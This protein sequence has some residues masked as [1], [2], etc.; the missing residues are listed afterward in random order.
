[1]ETSCF[2]SVFH[3]IMSTPCFPYALNFLALFFFFITYIPHSYSQ[4]SPD[5]IQIKKELSLAESYLVSFKNDSARMILEKLLVKLEARNQLGTPLGIRTQLAEATALERDNKDTAAIQKLLHVQQ[6]SREGELWAYFSKSSLVLA[7]L[8][9]KLDRPSASLEQLRLADAAIKAYH[10]EENYPNYAI[11]MASWQRIFG[12]RDSA[13]F[14]AREALAT[15]PL[16][17]LVLEEAIGHMLMGML[18]RDSSDYAS[19]QHYFSGLRL[20]KQLEDYTGCSYMFHGIAQ[21]YDR[22]GKPRL[23]L[24]YTDSMISIAKKAISLGNEN[25]YSLSRTYRFRGKLYKEM[26]QNDSAFYYQQKGYEM[27]L[28][29]MQQSIS[30][31]VIEI[32]AK[33]RDEKKG[34]I[35]EEQSLQIK[36]DRIRRNGLI[37]FILITLLFSTVLG[38]YYLRLKKANEKTQQQATTLQQLIEARS[39]FFANISHELRTPL[40]LILGPLSAILEQHREWDK[41]II[42]SQLQMIRRNGNSLMKLVE[43]I[44]DITRLEQ[45]KMHL[46]E[47][48][49]NLPAFVESIFSNFI[50]AFTSQKLT[51]GL[52][53]DVEKSL[54][55]SLDQMKLEKVLNNFLSNAMKHTSAGGDVSFYLQEIDDKLEIKISDTGKGIHPDDLPFIFDRFYQGKLDTDKPSG[56][57]GIGLSLVADIANLMGAEVSVEST[58]GTGSTFTFLMPKNVLE[59]VIFSGEIYDEQLASET[60]VAD[61]GSDFSI[62]VVEDNLDMQEFIRQSLLSRF[63]QV[64][65]AGNGVEALELLAKKGHNIDLIVTDMMMPEMDGLTLVETIREQPLLSAI[66]VIM[67]TALATEEDRLT[68]LRTGVDDYLTK[69]FSVNE[70]E[71]RAKNLLFNYQQRRI[72]LQEEGKSVESLDAATSDQEWMNDLEQTIKNLLPRNTILSVEQLAE[73]VHLSTRQLS[74]KVKICTGM[75]PGKFI[76]EVQLQTARR[77]ITESNFESLLEVA[78]KSGFEHQ[79]TFSTSFKNRFGK[80]PGEYLKAHLREV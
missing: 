70:L 35:L 16:Y 42:R 60:L 33:Y 31:K 41:K 69:P 46:N 74:R 54:W 64:I 43:E 21:Y 78:Q 79:T 1:M 73:S 25:H 17:G 72:W 49:I 19:V 15:A 3:C 8:Y 58:L 38:Y 37:V 5:S 62:L 65:I 53:L 66:P 7:N 48:S 59:P 29:L 77:Y 36:L 30:D 50:P 28:E 24:A 55:V 12:Q 80:P 39:R 56:G 10:L 20:Y 34:Q 67:L 45:N 61:L 14:F 76:K 51:Y 13:H 47:R 32:D 75:P 27:E 26:G 11:R 4:A 2:A 52:H 6:A 44:L 57:S 23:A 22:N 9:E 68:A 18:M 71:V 63:K 40:T